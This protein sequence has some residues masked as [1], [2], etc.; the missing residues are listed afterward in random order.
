MSQLAIAWCARNP[1]VSTVITGANRVQQV[2]ENMDAIDV[3]PLVDDEIMVR[4]EAAATASA[5]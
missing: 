4:I 2:G 5:R 3:L 1:D